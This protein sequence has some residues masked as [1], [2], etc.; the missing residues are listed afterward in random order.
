MKTTFAT[1]LQK[2]SFLLIF[3]TLFF[4]GC[5]GLDISNPGPLPALPSP[6]SEVNVP[7]VF[8]KKT[9]N[10]LIN[11]QI[12]NQL[13]A[14]DDLEIGNGIEGNLSLSRNGQ[15]LSSALDSQQ[16]TIQLPMKIQGEIGLS[17]SGLGSLFRGKVPIDNE[18]APTFKLNPEINPDW[19]LS[20][21]DFE[22]LSLGGNLSLD[23]LGMQ[24]DLS[25]MLEREIKQWA[26]EYFQPDQKLVNLKPIVDLAW[27]Q[28]GRPFQVDW[29][30]GVSGFSIRPKRVMFKEFFDQNENLT[31]WMGLAGQIQTHPADATPSRAFPLPNLSENTSD[32]NTL[33]ILLPTAISF[34]ELD[35]ILGENLNGRSF[36]VDSKTV[37][38][39]DELRSKAFGELIAI[40]TDFVADRSNGKTV[41][42]RLFVV[43]KPSYDSE[44]QALTFEDVN[45]KVIS[46]QSS[47]NFGIALK[48]RKI[49]RQIEKLAVFPIGDLLQESTEGIRERLGLNTPIADLQIEN[50]EIIPEGFY[51]SANGL[52]IYVQANGNVGVNW[53]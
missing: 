45:F 23:V 15:I 12:P 16:M 47:A 43:G 49:I 9:L 38:T 53:K 6:D 21:K 44:A 19:T 30:Q 10:R 1:Q 3:P 7:L 41:D 27:E 51:P 5:K 36:R 8:P 2:Y 26:A 11:S 34:D 24:V 50:L 14:Q 37:L 39:L 32:E 48:K 29:Q 52:R 17:Q 33:K 20:V 31:I 40:E 22:L 42:G 18:F 28:V 13:I 46:D 4:L 35:Q 25:K